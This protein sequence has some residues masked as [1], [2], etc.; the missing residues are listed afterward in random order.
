MSKPGVNG[1]P[2]EREAFDALERA[3]TQTLDRL[4]AMNDR[5]AA[6]EARSA[7]LGELMKRFTG[8]ETEAGRLLSR[9]KLLEDENLD[10]RSRLDQGR[11][12]VER[13]LAKIRFLEN[14]A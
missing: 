5:V 1:G 9:L 13:L 3:V 7:E 10:L 2:P 14:Q 11:E 8:D 12:G 6:A 4:R